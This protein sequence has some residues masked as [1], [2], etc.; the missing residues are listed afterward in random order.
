MVHERQEAKVGFW[1][2]VSMRDHGHNEVRRCHGTEA[3][4]VWGRRSC[5]RVGPHATRVCVATAKRQPEAENDEAGGE[6][7]GRGLG[8]VSWA[9]VDMPVPATAY[10]LSVSGGGRNI[11]EVWQ[12]YR[13]N[14]AF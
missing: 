5:R 1:V 14:R 9:K 4:R 13:A 11:F 10:M 7:K 6:T 3:R 12:V 2:R 8:R